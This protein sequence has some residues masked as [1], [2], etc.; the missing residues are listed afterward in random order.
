MPTHA[1]PKCSRLLRQSGAIELDGRALAV[2]QCDECLRPGTMF[3]EPVEL[4][5][6]FTVD[7]DG[8][9]EIPEGAGSS[10]GSSTTRPPCHPVRWPPTA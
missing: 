8:K 6:T 7:E 5:F 3:G 4:A 1:C 10:R 2:Y 9:V